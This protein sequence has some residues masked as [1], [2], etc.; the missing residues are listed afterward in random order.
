MRIFLFLFLYFGLLGTNQAHT[1]SSNKLIYIENKGQWDTNVIYKTSIKNGAIFLER[2]KITVNVAE[3]NS[4]KFDSAFDFNRQTRG[5][6]Y[7]IEFVNSNSQTQIS[8][9]KVFS[10]YFNYFLGADPTKW[11]GGCK[12]YE[13]IRYKDIYP[14]IDLVISSSYFQPKYTFFLRSGAKVS[15]IQMKFNGLSSL[16]LTNKGD[17]VSAT[18]LGDIIDEKPITF[19][20]QEGQITDIKSN[21]LLI[22]NIVRFDVDLKEIRSGQILEIDPQIIFSSFSGSTADNFGA[23]ATYDFAGNLYGTGLVFG[24]GYPTTTGAY[25]TSFGGQSDIGI[26]KF[27]P[28]GNARIYSTYIG[29][30]SF[31]VPHSLVVDQNNR[32][33]LLST[34][35]ST[36]FPTTSG[37]FRTTHAGGPPLNTPS[38]PIPSL[39]G[40]GV[41]Y[42]NGADIAITKFNP[43]GTGLVGS[44]FFGGSG[45]D[46]VGIST[47]LVKNYGDGIRGEIETDTFGNIY[48]VSL[49]NSTN[50]PTVSGGF[51]TTN[52]GGY[53]GILAKFNTNLTTL[54]SFSY[55]GGSS[56]DALYDMCFDN[57]GN[58]VAAGGTASSNIGATSGVVNGTYSGGTDGM[59]VSLN[60]NL[61]TLR[62]ATYY[63]TNSYDQIYFVETDNSNRVYVFGQTTHNATNYYLFNA[64]YSIPH[65]GQFVSILNPSVTAKVRSTMFGRG[66]QNP[67]ISPTAFLVDYCDKIFITGWGSNLGSFNTFSLNTSGLPVT[68]NAFQSTTLGNGFYMMILEGDL[69]SL[70]YGSFF[71]G[72][73]TLSEEHV[74][75]GTSRFDK[76][77][78]V[79]HAVCAGCGGQQNFPIYP[80]ATSVVG[81]TNNSGKCN[82]GV[83]KFDFGLPVAADFNYTPACAPASIKMNNFS[84]TVSPNTQFFWLFSNGATSMLKEPT[85]T[86][87]SP[88]IYTARLIV[89]DTTSCN[90]ADTITKNIIV[91]GTTADT[92]TDKTICP[93]SSIR[94]G[95]TNIK[96]TGI[97]FSWTPTNTLDDPTILSP[98]ASPTVTTQYRLVIQKTGCTD[99]FYQNVIIDSPKILTILGD[100]ITCVGA[101]IVYTT[102]FYNQGNYDWLPKNI[103]SKSN[104]DTAEYTFTALP[105]TITVNYTSPFGCISTARKTIIAGAPTLSIEADT[106]VCKGDVINLIAKSNFQGGI[107]SFSPSIAPLTQNGDTTRFIVDTTMK[108]E[109]TKTISANC[110]AKD[111]IQFK[112]LKDA[113]NW[114]IDSIV[115]WNEQVV[116]TSNL[117]PNYSILWQ[118]TANLLSPQGSSPAIFN[119]NNTNRKVYIQVN[120]NKKSFCRY[121]DSVLVKFV[122]LFMDI[123][124]DSLKC[125]DS[126]VTIKHS[127]AKGA[128]VQWKPSILLMNQT[129]SSATFR[130]PKTG[131]YTMV[132]IDNNCTL[133]DSLRVRIVNDLVLLSGDSLICPGDTASLQVTNLSGAKYQWTPFPPIIGKADTARIRALPLQSQMFYVHIQDTHKCYIFDSFF[134]R[135]LDSQFTT[136]ADFIA[137][138]NC[139]NS[140]IAFTNTSR[141]VSSTPSYSWNFNGQGTSTQTNPNFTFTSYGLQNVT[142]IVQDNS[143]CNK[144]DT[145]VKP[146]YILNNAFSTLPAIKSCKGDSVVIGLKGVID[147]SATVTWTPNGQMNGSSS[148]APKVKVNAQTTF[149]ALISKNGC[150]DTLEQTVLIDTIRPLTI[151]GPTVVCRLEEATY[152][153]TNYPTGNYQWEPF[154]QIAYQNKDSAKII[155]NSNSIIKAI[156]TSDYNCISRDSLNVQVVLAALNL[157][158]DTIGCKG[159]ILTINYSTNLLGGTYTFTPSSNILSQ[160][161]TSAQFRVDTTKN[162]RVDY[163]VNNACFS[164]KTITFKLLQDAV[165][166][167]VDTI[168]CK[169]QTI[170]AS[171]NVNP[172]WDFLWNPVGLLQTNQGSSPAAFGPFN[173]DSNI[174]IQATLKSRPSCE[175][176]DTAR[177][178]L[179]ENNIKILGPNSNCKDSF[180]NLSATFVPN[181]TYT[182]GPNNALFNAVVNNA[183]FKTDQ[184]RTYYV[185]AQFKNLCSAVDSHFVFAGN[186]NLKLW[187][188]TVV[189]ANDT[190]SLNAT[191]LNGAA[192]QWSTGATTNR[193][194]VTVT[195]PSIYR[196]SVIDSNNCLLKD[197]IQVKLFDNSIFKFQTRD[198]IVCKFDTVK[199]EVPNWPNITYQWAP[200]QPILSGQGTHKIRAWITQNTK[201][202]ILATLMRGS[203][204]CSVYDSITMRKDTAFLKI[205]GNKLVCKGDTITLNANFNPSFTYSWN[206][207]NWIVQNRNSA[208]YKVIDS[209]LVICSAN[210]SSFGKCRYRD[211]VR[212]DYSRYLDDLIVTANPN[213]IEYGSKTILQAQASNIVGYVWS[214]AKTLDNRFIPMPE[215]KPDTTTTYYVEVRD[216]LGC[217]SGDSVIVTVF[218]EICDDPEVYIPTGFTPNKDGKNDALYVMGDNIQKM[219]LMIYD[220]WGQMVFESDNQKKGWDGTYKG[221]ELEPGV[222][223]YYLY[224]ECIGGASMSK[225]GNITLLK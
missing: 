101:N 214:P 194:I 19:L 186:P 159:E 97:T 205:S 72:T 48:L 35:S 179:F 189:C 107:L 64:T 113:V 12:G 54:L 224:V 15:D 209:M 24:T 57:T 156:Y 225:K 18:V 182:W 39:N 204:S 62:Y 152:T 176:K 37:A 193:T 61:T 196:L 172:Q 188:D 63:G 17:L 67:D 200:T 99:T 77:G 207:T 74:D 130:V 203:L 38:N 128:N 70:Y 171:A 50:L 149:R 110:I 134:V 202:D 164:S 26:T 90:I 111:T 187:A 13:D 69:S 89:R 183:I 4:H 32:L 30:T 223:A 129:D 33:I 22:D 173:S 150:V 82:L 146:I 8:A 58:I 102:N 36:N 75:G 92:L 119:F 34:T 103:L 143:S 185:T 192:Y 212:V 121:T 27:S 127:S 160:T 117:N 123:K 114:N 151:N 20:H 49:S 208:S 181:T 5:H 86:F 25:Q 153:A 133:Q 216:P 43:T 16:H 66:N 166:W 94:I 83:I 106:I 221:I 95:F 165:N 100:S 112:L 201:F 29:G 23:S 136:K 59:I 145:I 109:V 190:V 199:L 87:T 79:Y 135:H 65:S 47:D 41:S 138:T 218:Y 161:S 178:R 142:L 52:S 31:D 56:D 177:I 88:G 7:N 206:P 108:L 2:N 139:Q 42:P 140:T 105:A 155:I 10:E 73:T 126:L 14:N 46:G 217:R 124:A 68:G 71:G 104:R 115:C 98:F 197:S 147:P 210:N 53:D 198:S 144:T 157:T 81:P 21:F 11:Q 80:N 55:I 211:S 122:D 85:I 148:F 167:Q 78:I 51:K 215:A 44:S 195:Q 158:M 141:S 6:A 76:N 170:A 169:G 219:H 9:E 45:T 118:P 163:R 91:L 116:A 93:G 220:R 3:N 222:F 40:L 174:M 213:R 96:D 162:I 60:N 184:S 28:T 137:N 191:P 84:H 131:F 168:I 1:Q 180:I 125:K 132:V 175:F 154:S 120:H